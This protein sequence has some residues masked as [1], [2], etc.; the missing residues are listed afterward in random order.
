[1]DA[2]PLP[3]HRLRFFLRDF[4]VVEA[5]AHYVPGQALAAYLA[6]RRNWVTLLDA[7]WIGTG[8]RIRR[9]VLRIQQVLWVEAR[10]ELPAAVPAAGALLRQ[11]EVRLEGGLILHGSVPAHPRQ[12][13][14][15]W[16]ESAGPF[17]PLMAAHLLRSGRPPRSTNV[18][19]RDVAIHR[20]GIQTVSEVGP[21]PGDDTSIAVAPADGAR[22]GA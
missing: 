8:E 7:H 3:V 5:D 21:V 16:L 2:T 17:V 1:M 14:A 22:A 13:L 19:L 6:R 9:V 11:V 18:V 10:G 20:D 15:D 12:R 4:R